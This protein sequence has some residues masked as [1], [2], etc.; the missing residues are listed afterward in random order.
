MKS[1]WRALAQN[2]STN[3]YTLTRF[4]DCVANLAEESLG[5]PGCARIAVVWPGDPLFR[6]GRGRG[7]AIHYRLGTGCF[8]PGD[9]RDFQLRGQ[10]RADFVSVSNIHAARADRLVG[11]L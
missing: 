10:R 3:E 7:A 1:L 6:P 9:V 11:K 2:L 4:S 8:L 5:V